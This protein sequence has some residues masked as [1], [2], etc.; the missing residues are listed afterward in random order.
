MSKKNDPVSL[1]RE[2]PQAKPSSFTRFDPEGSGYDYK[3][4][5]KSGIK[6]NKKD[7]HWQSRDPK[8][9]QILKGRSHPTFYKTVEGEKRAGY[10]IYRKENGKY[11]SRPKNSD[12]KK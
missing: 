7:G 1:A 9:G 3:R 11:Y 8:T 2:G 12:K 10:E 6:P 4:A 5:I